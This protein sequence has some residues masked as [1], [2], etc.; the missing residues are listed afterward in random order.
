MHCIR[1]R[2]ENVRR[3]FVGGLGVRCG[4]S[5]SGIPAQEAETG[6]HD[7]ALQPPNLLMQRR[8]IPPADL[9]FKILICHSFISFIPSLR[10]H[11]HNTLKSN[12][13]LLDLLPKCHPAPHSSSPSQPQVLSSSQPTSTTLP[14]LDP[15][16]V[17]YTYQRISHPPPYPLIP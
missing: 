10:V 11:T 7:S 16:P 8:V 6:P 3:T 5:R 12:Q 1:A 14:F 17:R 4:W 9:L 15:K 13:E 2:E